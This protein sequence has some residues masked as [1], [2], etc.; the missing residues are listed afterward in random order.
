VLGTASVAEAYEPDPELLEAAEQEGALTII[1]GMPQVAMQAFAARFNEKYPSI[2]IEIERQQ[3]LAVY[4]KFNAET[5][6]GANLRDIVMVADVGAY[7]KLVADGMIMNHRVPNDEDIPDR[8]KIDGYAYVAYLTEIV[9]A[10]NAQL[11]SEEEGEVLREWEG[12]LDPRWK[13]R[14]GT[15]YPSGGSSYGPLY[16]YLHSE[17]SDRFGEDFL[18]GVAGQDPQI[19]SS[20]ATALERL[21][22]GETVVQFT[23]WESHILPKW[24]RGAPIRWYAPKPTPSYGNS[25]FGIAAKAPHPNAA[26]LFLNWFMSDEGATAVNEIYSSKSTVSNHVDQRDL[27]DESWYMPITDTYTPDPDGWIEHRDADVQLWSEIFDFK[28]GIK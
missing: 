27:P 7:R 24:E 2:N 5:R 22:S 13:G 26:K 14:I 19:F 1:H 25:Y 15:T 8:F 18:R 16:M 21:I 3:G 17:Y 20:T 23:H 28:P 4:E 10:V 12:I 11:V 9:I 6:G